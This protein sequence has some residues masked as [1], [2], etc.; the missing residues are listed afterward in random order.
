MANNQ[1]ETPVPSTPENAAPTPAPAAAV[2]AGQAVEGAVA[3]TSNPTEYSAPDADRK[4]AFENGAFGDEAE[5]VE[6]P[7]KPVGDEPGKTY[8]PESV[9]SG[10]P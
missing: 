8:E 7:A 1:S 5:H 2:E 9:V 3:A 6:G 4:D 10:C